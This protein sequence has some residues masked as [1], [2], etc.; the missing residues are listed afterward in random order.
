MRH[1]WIPIFCLFFSLGWGSAQSEEEAASSPVDL[2]TLLSKTAIYVGDVFEYRISVRHSSEF[3]F[4]TQEFEER[5]VVRPFELVEF[6]IDQKVVGEEVLL[7]LVLA[8]VCYEPPG[9]V[10]IPSLNLFYYPSDSL[11]QAGSDTQQDIPASVLRVPPQRIQLQSTLLGEGD[12][13][14]DTV[15]LVPFPRSDLILPA[16]SAGLLFLVAVGA[17]IAGVRYARLK[18]EDQPDQLEQLREETLHS[19]RQVQQ[20]G[21]SQ[22][23]DPDLYLEVSK[24]LRHYIEVRFGVLSQALTPEEVGEE[25]EGSTDPEFASQVETVLELCDRLFFDGAPSPAP[26]LEDLCSQ[27]TNL[28]LSRSIESP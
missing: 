18:K 25:L 12:Q 5:L 14:R 28:V 20:K 15:R 13:L 24:V 8:L 21:A 27:A 3:A 23:Q 22:G 17:I 10:E 4:V 19:L 9:V 7:E 2:V 26:D 16:L 1:A 11:A 6:Q